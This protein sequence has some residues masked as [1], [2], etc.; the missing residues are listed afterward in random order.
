MIDY[1]HYF[2][3]KDTANKILIHTY[4]EE[5][6]QSTV[7]FFHLIDNFYLYYQEIDKKSNHLRTKFKNTLT[8][9]LAHVVG[10]WM[11]VYAQQCLDST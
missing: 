9:V 5:E 7:R 2:F 6:A 3:G 1:K 11:V 8:L 4:R 10:V